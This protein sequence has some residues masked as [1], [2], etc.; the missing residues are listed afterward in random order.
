[1]SFRFEQAAGA[2]VVLLVLADVFL[3]VLYARAGTGILSERL[4]RVHWRLFKPFSRLFGRNRGK[5]LSFCAP[6]SLVSLVAAWALLLALGTGMIV[7]PALGNAVRRSTG[8]TPRDFTT[9]V[10]VGATSLSFVGPGDF[11]PNTL[12]Y[13]LLFLFDSLVGVSVMTMTLTYLMQVYTA[14]RERNTFGLKLY[15]MSNETSDAAE[16]LASL[17]AQGRFDATYSVLAEMAAEAAK[18]KE[19][20]HFYPMLALFRF[21]DPF[22]SMSAPI[23]LGLDMV[24]LIKSALDDEEFAW[25]KE[26]TAITLLWRALIRQTDLLD[27]AFAFGGEAAHGEPPDAATR[28]RW[29]RRY[30]AA[31]ERLRTAGIRTRADVERGVEIYSTLRADWE[32]RIV[33]LAPAMEYN[34]SEIDPGGTHPA[35]TE[36]LPD[37]RNRLTAIS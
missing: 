32:H 34:L 9:A 27:Q 36:G 2:V 23:A 14:L 37:F 16:L 30:L 20:H 24:A 28:E 3:T 17:G 8:A 12:P 18:V 7:H 1:M 6:S 35:T 13:R 22:Y 26:S 10:Y 4:A 19:A 31:S 25:L 15:L 33:M 21:R 29:R 11:A 5:V